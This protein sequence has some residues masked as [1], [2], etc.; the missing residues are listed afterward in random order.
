MAIT[1]SSSSVSTPDVPSAIATVVVGTVR[2]DA[3]GA[4]AALRQVR[5]ETMERHPQFTWRFVLATDR[6][7]DRVLATITELP[8]PVLLV[9]GGADRINHVTGSERIARALGA[10]CTLRVYEDVPHKPHCDP[11]SARILDDVVSWLDERC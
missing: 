7:I 6:A 3:A 9:H 10:R 5:S 11:E 2:D 1:G 8:A 4:E